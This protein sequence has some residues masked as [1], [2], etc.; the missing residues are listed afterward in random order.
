MLLNPASML[1]QQLQACGDGVLTLAAEF[2]IAQD[3]VNW[4]AC[5]PQALEKLNPDYILPGIIAIA[6]IIIAPNG[7]YHQ[8]SAFIIAQCMSTKTGN[9]RHLLYR[10]YLISYL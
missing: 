3:I 2:G 9:S 5:R 7:L 10:Q 8:T 6:M 1:L 4:H